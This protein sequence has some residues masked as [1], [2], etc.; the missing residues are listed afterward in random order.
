MAT[1]RSGSKTY[2]NQ[3]VKEWNEFF[4]NPLEE[5]VYL[6]V[7][8]NSDSLTVKAFTQ[9]GSLIDEWSLKKGQGEQRSA[10]NRAGKKQSVLCNIGW[11][12]VIL[13]Q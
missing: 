9:S 13:R 3:S 4:Y 5:P 2:P 7:M 8:V 6:T 10:S 11:R 1:R 12:Y